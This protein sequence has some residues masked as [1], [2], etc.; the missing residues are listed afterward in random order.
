[1][2]IE[3]WHPPQP[4]QYGEPPIDMV[5]IGVLSAAMGAA[6]AA[7]VWTISPVPMAIIKTRAHSRL[8]EQYAMKPRITSAPS[9]FKLI[10]DPGQPRTAA[11]VVAFAQF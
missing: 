1:M 11:D 3:E 6:I 7:T 10:A 8:D 2:V 5:G 9:R 4:R